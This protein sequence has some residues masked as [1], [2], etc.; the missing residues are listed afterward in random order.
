MIGDVVRWLRARSPVVP[1]STRDDLLAEYERLVRQ[2]EETDPFLTFAPPGHFYSPIPEMSEAMAHVS[3]VFADRPDSLPGIDLRLDAQLEL[4]SRLVRF[5]EDFDAPASRIAGRRYFTDNPS[6]GRGDALVLESMLRELRP[7][8]IVEIGSGYSSALMLDT[9]DRYY[10]GRPVS[11]TFIE[12]HADVL[13]SRF[14]R[15][16]AAR[17]EIV[18]RPLQAVDPTRFD[19]LAAGDLLFIDST[20]VVR[21]G[22]DVL[23][24]ILEILPRLRPGVLVHVHDIFYPFEYPPEW[25]AGGRVWGE[26]YLLRAFLAEN[27][28]Y[29]VM[30][31]PNC[32]Q[33][34]A[35]ER[36]REVAP[37]LVDEGFGSI[38]LR[39]R[40][41]GIDR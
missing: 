23:H 12:P 26:A 14:L 30:L 15:G 13:R 16:D 32:L 41:D 10:A 34:I 24:E 1:R 36:F 35:A 8:R 2:R 20:H 40:V 25:V 18:E 28:E 6:F 11:L 9:F 3:A 37:K 19:K 21:P 29:E 7:G 33:A 22:S 27:S 38:W 17:C 31:W 5:Q 4:A 39:R